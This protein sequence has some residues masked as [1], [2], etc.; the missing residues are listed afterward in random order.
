M[1][2]SRKQPGWYWGLQGPFQTKAKAVAA[3]KIAQEFDGKLQ[4][5]QIF[6]VVVDKKEW[7]PPSNLVKK[8]KRM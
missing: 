4:K 6:T 7:K 8:F 3:S 1:T 2:F 5:D